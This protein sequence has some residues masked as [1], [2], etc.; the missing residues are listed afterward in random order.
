VEKF[1]ATVRTQIRKN[2]SDGLKIS[3]Y[4]TKTMAFTGRLAIGSKI[5]II[6]EVI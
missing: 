1:I 5:I 4:K 6:N 2:Q 3:T